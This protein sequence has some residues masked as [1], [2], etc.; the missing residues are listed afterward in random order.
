M[1]LDGYQLTETIYEGRH[2]LVQR[3]IRQQD[4][5]PVVVKMLQDRQPSF[6]DIAQFRHQHVISC[7]CEHPHIIRSLALERCGNG[8]ALVMEDRG[9]QSLSSYWRQ[10]ERTVEEFLAI[11]IQLAEAMRYLNEKRIIHKDIKPANI[12]IH[13][14]TRQI[15]LIDF[16]ISSLLPK[17]EQQIKSPELLEGT[18]AYLSPEQTGRMNRGVDYRTDF[19]SLG[20][21]FYELLTGEL[22]FQATEAMGLVYCHLAQSPTFPASAQGS[23]PVMVQ[24][25]ALKLMEKKAEDR[26]QNALGLKHDLQRCLADLEAYDEVLPFELGQQDI[27]D[28]F[29]LS[30]TLYGRQQE[31]KTLL[32]AF[33]RAIEGSTEVV[34]VSGFSGIGK[35]AIINEV[36]KPIVKQRGYFIKGK[37]DQFNRNLPLSGFIQALRNLI[38]QIL[39]ESDQQLDRWRQEVTE[40]VGSNGQVL[41]EMLPE[42]ALLI[43][44]QP[45]APPTK[46][47]TAQNRF[48]LLL[49][50]FIQ[51]FATAEHPLVICLDDWQWADA[52]SLQFFKILV[53]QPVGH[54]LILGAYRDNEMSSAHPTRV[55]LSELRHGG[56]ALTTITLA[57]LPQ[58]DIN[59]LVAATLHTAAVKTQYLSE[60]V[61]QKTQGNPFFTTQFLT[62]LY[63]Q[64]QITFDYQLGTWHWDLEE[65]QRLALTDDVVQLMQERL[66]KLPETT[67]VLLKTAACLGNDFELLPLMGALEQSFTEVVT[68][69]WL[70]IKEGL[71]VPLNGVI[72]PLGTAHVQFMGGEQG[73]AYRFL[74]DRVQ[75]AAYDL[76]TVVERQVVHLRIGRQL[77]QAVTLTDEQLFAIAN[78]FRIALDLVVE[79]TERANLIPLYRHVARKAQGAIAYGTAAECL[80]IALQLAQE[81]GS[82]STILQELYGQSAEVAYLRQDWEQMELFAN[83]TLALTTD[84]L[85]LVSIYKIRISAYVMQSKIQEAIALGLEILADLGHPL[86]VDANAEMVAA[87]LQVLQHSLQ[88]HQ[89]SPSTLADLPEMGDRRALAVMDVLAFFYTAAHKSNLYLSQLITLKMVQLSVDFGNTAL[90]SVGYVFLGLFFSQQDNHRAAYAY[91]QLAIKMLDR[92][93]GRELKAKV[94]NFVQVFIWHWQA[95]IRETIAPLQEAYNIGIET[96]DLEFAGLNASLVCQHQYWA[97]YELRGL[98]KKMA[99]YGELI[100]HLAAFQGVLNLLGKA[101]NPLV[102]VGTA[103]DERELLPRY[104]TAN[105]RIALLNLYLHKLVLAVILNEP[106][107]ALAL[108]KLGW[109]YVESVRSMLTYP[110]FHFYGAL[111]H[112][113]QFKLG[114][115]TTLEPLAAVTTIRTRLRTWAEQAPSTYLHKV[116]LIVAE[117]A[118]VMGEITT[119]IAAYDQAIAGAKQYKFLQEEAIANELAARFY[120]EW[121]RE[122]IAAIYLQEAYYAYAYWG[123]IAKIDQLEEQYTALLG[124]ILQRNLPPWLTSPFASLDNDFQQ[125]L[126]PHT[127]KNAAQFSNGFTT[128]LDLSVLLQAAQS[129]SITAELD[130]LLAEIVELILTNAGAQKACLLI[131]DDHQW[132]LRAIAELTEQNAIAINTQAVPL[133]SHSPLPVPL[134]QYVKNTQKSIIIDE[135]ETD[136]SGILKGYLLKYQPQSVFCLPLLNKGRNVAII[137]L[138]HATMK[139]V[140]TPQRQTMLEFLCTQA[141]VALEN[142]RLYHE[143]QQAFQ[144]IQYKEAQARAIFEAAN[145]GLLI[146]DLETGRI[147]D[148]NPT[149]CEIHGYDLSEI[150]QLDPRDLIPTKYHWKF[151][152]FLNTVKSGQ[153]FICEAAC[154]RTDGTPFFIEINSVP[155][156]Y[157]GKYCGLSVVRDV[158]TSRSLKDSIQEKNRSLEK[159][160]A[161]LQGAQ[162]QMV[163]SEKMSALGSLVAG[164]A[165]EINNPTGFLQGNIQPA[166]EYVQDLLGLIDLYGEFYPDPVPEIVEEIEAIDLAFVR[167]DILKLLDSM[168]LG[169]ERI[170]N[171][172]DSLRTF[173]RQ[174]LDHMVRFNLHDGLNSTLLILKHR[175]KANELRPAIKIKTDYGNLPEVL[176]FPGQINQVFMNLLANAIDAL[177]DGNG[178]RPYEE[179]QKHPN[180]ITIR[181][182]P[183]ST[184]RVQVQISDN[185]C[186]MSAATQ[187]QIF[188]QGFTTKDVGKG[189]GLGMAIAYKIITDKHRGSIVCGSALNVGTTFTITL[190]INPHT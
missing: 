151:E 128:S 24:A 155:F 5:Q 72:L 17:E 86:P 133:N 30:E 134:I 58:T 77:Q 185:G 177:E 80:A 2:T 164:V 91:G 172:S 1:D 50:S 125:T 49:R 73:N 78:H 126:A 31:I 117:Q 87:A 190:P 111:A 115:I 98:A 13:P 102:L 57:P 44:E 90:S 84:P 95:P 129:L 139:G 22:P 61:Y 82:S 32:Q 6:V 123:A 188:D 171:I 114:E 47:D 85:A 148:A 189:T 152:S 165:H 119:A 137:Y 89:F 69:L 118:R 99:D 124:G 63:E 135:L 160:M 140:F 175:T 92:F 81:L 162:L 184:D 156:C 157:N 173:S 19:Y 131:P 65:V 94:Y 53:S 179:L 143:T 174:D 62:S 88:E 14:E 183:L 34:M 29:L 93:D 109:D 170:R 180:V 43:G 74:H 83:Q 163:Q 38:Q 159:A 55:T 112:L 36:H 149:Y 56:H 79:P 167:E 113:G 70:A 153:E 76:L 20:V 16:S 161:D 100:G 27:S 150:L 23:I 127:T 59:E 146:T 104:Q 178:D 97:G 52:T 107:R 138:E 186:G 60:L 8:Y 11:A 64:G 116:H 45:P 176:C 46:G 37:F 67:Q 21:T 130:Q 26:Y 9:M 75:Q 145:D 121:G 120:L 181:T 182:I 187:R 169:V 18:L 122:K 147:I 166:M 132:Q 25:I 35:T 108:A 39:T 68:G 101:E 28:R 103:Y 7:D 71:I 33:T 3:G 158:T 105:N 136:I 4:Q 41:M 142:S 96:G 168:K 42:L 154:V 66:V 10:V 15:A 141:A 54:L 106:Q 12:L 110:L 48:N 144:E 51:I 40:V